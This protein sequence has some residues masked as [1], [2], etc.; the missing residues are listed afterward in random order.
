MSLFN[1]EDDDEETGFCRSES[2]P[3]QTRCDDDDVKMLV[4]QVRG[5]DLF[6]FHMK[7]AE[8][9]TDTYSETMDKRLVSRERNPGNHHQCVGTTSR[10]KRGVIRCIKNYQ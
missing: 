3:F 4:R 8:E 7:S 2:L 9:G 1:I 10:G 5:F 6:R